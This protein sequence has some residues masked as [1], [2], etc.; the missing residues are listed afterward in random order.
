MFLVAVLLVAINELDKVFNF[1]LLI[2]P[3]LVL[4]ALAL[5]VWW[6]GSLLSSF[7]YRRWKRMVSLAVAPAISTAAILFLGHFGVTFERIRFEL[8]KPYY[9]AEIARVP[10]E[11]GPRFKIFKW[12]ETGGVAAANVFYTL[13]FDESDEIAVPPTAR[14]TDWLRKV[15]RLCP[16]TQMCSILQPNPPDHSVDVTKVS[17]HFYLVTEVY[18]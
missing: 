1:Y 12:G 6:I 4:P 17:G 13:A 7:R 11:D 3:L 16:G 9:F 5:G 14:S 2:I 15:S 10:K 8:L 18:R